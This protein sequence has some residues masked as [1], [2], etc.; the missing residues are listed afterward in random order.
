M[1]ETGDAA[2]NVNSSIFRDESIKLIK[3]FLALL[4][5]PDK[6]IW[7]NLSPYEKD[8]IIGNG[9]GRTAM[10]R[11][12]LAQDYILKQFTASLTFPE[13]GV[14][15]AF[16]DRI[17]RDAQAKFGTTDIPVDAFNKV[18]IMPDRAEVFEKDGS[19]YVTDAHLKVMLETDYMAAGAVTDSTKAQDKMRYDRDA[20]NSIFREVI[21]PAIEKEVNE[22]RNFDTLRQIYHAQILAVWYKVKL[23]NGILAQVYV[24]RNKT[25]GVHAKD[26]F[27]PQKIYARYL[28]AFRGAMLFLVETLQDSPTVFS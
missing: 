10:G 19:V 18:W 22:G 21:I 28:D 17:Y 13:V 11:D 16:W 23:E 1:L 24:D 25:M 15:K 14:G 7:V 20:S 12:L 2:V 9:L 3:Y 5:I 8:R 26:K 4:T 6:E 27:F